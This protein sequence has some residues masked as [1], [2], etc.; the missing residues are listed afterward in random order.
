MKSCEYGTR[1]CSTLKTSAKLSYFETLQLTARKRKLQCINI[2]EIGPLQH[3]FPRD[4][5]RDSFETSLEGF[6]FWVQCYKLLTFVI[7]EH[8]L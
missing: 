8:L 5:K 7:Y 1:L 3:N 4:R 2:Y 6:D